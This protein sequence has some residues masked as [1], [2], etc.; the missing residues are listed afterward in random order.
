MTH[1]PPSP[2]RQPA[3]SP[4]TPGGSGSISDFQIVWLDPPT[5]QPTFPLDHPYVE[6]VYT[7][8]VGAS[9]VL[10]LRRV[11]LLDRGDAVI[12]VDGVV[13]ASEL[14]LRSRDSRSLGSNSPFCGSCD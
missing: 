7:P 14:G 13:L 10:F 2:G 6:L 11:A 5:D 12:E 9:A 8:L 4:H 3:D 1:P